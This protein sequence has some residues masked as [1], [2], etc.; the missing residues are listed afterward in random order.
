MQFPW[1]SSLVS[2]MAWTYTDTNAAIHHFLMMFHHF[3]TS[4]SIFDHPQKTTHRV[5]WTIH[6]ITNKSKH[7]HDIPWHTMTVFNDNSHIMVNICCFQFLTN[8]SRIKWLNYPST[9]WHHRPWVSRHSAG[10][11][12]MLDARNLPRC[13]CGLLFVCLKAGKTTT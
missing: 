2:Q 9:W 1:Q 6:K 7:N 11:T 5:G 12:D 3:H 8:N 10:L 4:W 13:R